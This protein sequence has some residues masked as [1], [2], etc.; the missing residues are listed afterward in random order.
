[1]GCD[2]VGELQEALYRAAKAN[3]KR[4][5]HALYD[6]MWRPDVL[7]EAWA[8]VRANGGAAGVDGKTIEEIEREGVPLFL[9]GLARELR[10]KTYQPS[11]LRRVWIP[12]PNGKARGLGIP[13]VRDRVVQT[14]AKMLLEPIFEADFEPCSYGFRPGRSPHDA[15]AQVV[16]YLNFGCERV[17]DADITGCFD[18]IPKSALM[19][20]VARRV[21]DGAMLKMIRQWLDCGVLEGANLLYPDRVTPQPDFL[22]SY[23]TGR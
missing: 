21:V 8:R 1:M 3:A 19:K 22:S 20:A 17:I 14:A 12:K 11:P 18:N 7:A 23:G 4:R 10:E 16:S 13:T 5:F 2:K 9:E 15:V 6:K